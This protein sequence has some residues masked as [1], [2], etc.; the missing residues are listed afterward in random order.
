MT[1]S[2]KMRSLQHSAPSDLYA[3]RNVST[4]A[5]DTQPSFCGHFQVA[6]RSFNYITGRLSL[7]GKFIV[8]AI[9]GVGISHPILGFTVA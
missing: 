7:T 3:T 8:Q 4:A 2:M 6:R 9:C 1:T 5:D